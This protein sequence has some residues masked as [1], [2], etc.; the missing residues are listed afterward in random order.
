M[1]NRYQT[2]FNNQKINLKAVLFGLLMI[3]FNVAAFAQ[4]STG[5]VQGQ[6]VNSN[7]EP[8]GFVSVAI[9]NTTLGTTT[10][11]KGNFKIENVPAGVQTLILSG[12]TTEV[13]KQEIMV[14]AQEVLQV[15]LTGKEKTTSLQAVEITGRKEVT[16]KND[17]SFLGTRTATALKD[18]PQAIS[19]VTKE[20]MQDQQAF[21][22]G[23]VVKNISGV[24]QFSS[25]DDF[26]LRGFRSGSNQLLNGLR[27]SKGFWGQPLTN[28]LERIEVIK[29]P[30]SALFGNTDPGGTINRVTK[31]PLDISRQSIGFTVGSFNTYRA[32]ADF[33]GPMNEDKSL[34]YRLNLGY[35]NTE[36]YRNLQGMEAFMIAPSISFLPTAKTRVNFDMVYSANHSKLDRGQPIFGAAAGTSLYS[37]PTN[38]AIARGNDYLNEDYLYV[39]SSLSHQFTSQLSFNASYMKF[40]GKEDLMEHRTSNNFAVDGDGN[41]IPTLMEMQTIRRMQQTFND[42]V[43]AYL[44]YNFETGFLEHK[45]VGGYDY[46]Q[47]VIPV[48]G[49]SQNARGY[50]N[51]A[52]NGVI[53][54]YKPAD[55][56]KYL[57]DK[58]GN[59]VPNIP[60]FDLTNPDYSVANT[61]DYF[62][63]SSNIAT[64]K[65]YSNAIYLQDQVKLGKLQVLLGLRQEFYYDYLNYKKDNEEKVTQSALIPRLGLVYGINNNI[66][67]YATYAQGY[68]PQ[69]AGTLGDP[70][71]FGGPFDPLTSNMIEG[72]F[73]TEWFDQ[74]LTANLAVYQIE[75]NNILIN[76]RNSDNPDLLEQRG[77]ERARG[78][79]LDLTGNILPNLS[80]TANYAFNHTEITKS[81]DEKEI[82][83]IKENA[84]KHSGGM[85]VRYSIAKGALHGLG[86]GVGSNFTGIRNTFDTFLTDDNGNE[87]GLKL[88][89]YT[90]FDAALFY[91]INKFQISLK[92]NNLTNETHWTGGYGYT[93]LF[94]GAPR[95][96]LMS[97][98]YTF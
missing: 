25:Y 32:V 86:F 82:G 45:L 11:E 90:L 72:G 54:T 84:P 60:H 67:A 59:P 92:V 22:T 81:A 57:L 68:Q 12:L 88:P 38:F 77:Q 52:N 5:I 17:I 31:K 40:T 36:T 7:N 9:L 26:T 87:L 91:N 51:A 39:T 93:R 62:M 73:K 53:N 10:D 6:A 69:S 8:L 34:L 78:A 16:Y 13:V 83:R 18:V 85:W 35:E 15:K 43:A 20:V 95:H 4:T 28:N 80:V 46:Q 48:G 1:L 58:N 42:N 66:N 24:N 76:A 75:Q 23:D 98:A 50:R 56:A 33:T 49:S 74:R 65:Y 37:T 63:T 2:L 19:Y 3:F 64:S 55:K 61:S 21:R 29:G 94:P 79:E 41:Q 97:V 44:V 47:K 27:V 71:R 96:Y 14:T 89:A 30:A 70:E